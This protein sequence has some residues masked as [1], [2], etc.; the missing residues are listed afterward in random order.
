MQSRIS[1]D[2]VINLCSTAIDLIILTHQTGVSI[3][4][5]FNKIR[6]NILFLLALGFE[7][8]KQFA[9]KERQDELDFSK[10]LAATR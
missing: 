5:P 9:R 8:I 2:Y 4:D 10:E 1:N 7:K 3:E 6:K